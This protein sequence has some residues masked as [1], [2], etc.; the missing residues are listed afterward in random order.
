[1]T[2]GERKEKGRRGKK[3]VSHLT[4]KKKETT[5]LSI[6]TRWETREMEKEIKRRPEPLI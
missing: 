5:V 1:M 4:K 3:A 2:E 6:L